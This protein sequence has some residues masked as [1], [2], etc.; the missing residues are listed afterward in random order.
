M[1]MLKPFT[2]SV[3]VSRPSAPVIWLAIP[4]VR[5]DRPNTT[6][7]ISIFTPTFC[8]IGLNENQI[9]VVAAPIPMPAAS[10]PSPCDPT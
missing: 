8:V 1:K 9:A 4:K 5:I 10:T 3:P 6:T 2:A 7:A